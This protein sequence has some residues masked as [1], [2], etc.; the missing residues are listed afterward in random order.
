MGTP[1][2]VAS[3]RGFFVGLECKGEHGVV[4]PIQRRVLEM[5]RATGGV[6]EVVRTV[7]E[8]NDILNDIDLRR[9]GAV[10]W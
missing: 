9:Q 7:D 10:Q 8:V 6:G 1:D 5:I 2:I 3:Y 4:T